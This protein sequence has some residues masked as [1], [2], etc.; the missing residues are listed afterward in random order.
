MNTTKYSD[1]LEFSKIRTKQLFSIVVVCT[2][3]CEF[4]ENSRESL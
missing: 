1:S 3:W 4:F 2:V